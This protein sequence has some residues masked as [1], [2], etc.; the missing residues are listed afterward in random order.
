MK[1]IDSILDQMHVV[2]DELLEN[3]QSVYSLSQKKGINGEV[4]SI[5]KEQEEKFEK[6]VAL[7]GELKKEITFLGED[8]SS[9]LGKK[10]QEKIR[11]VQ[12]LNESFL[13]ALKIRQGI[14]KEELEKIRHDKRRLGKIEKA[15]VKRKRS[16]V[17]AIC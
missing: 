3:L 10:V 17:D 2:V 13:T 6:L 15:Y 16:K 5:Q 12:K 7:D 9:D 4:L 11:L 1:R 14:I 8:T